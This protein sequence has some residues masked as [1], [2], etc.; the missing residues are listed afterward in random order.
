MKPVVAFDV[1]I[2][3]TGTAY[4]ARVLAMNSRIDPVSQTIEIEASIVKHHPELLAG[5]SGTAH[6]VVAPK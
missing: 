6:F 4:E 3:E 1:A 5:M 2:D